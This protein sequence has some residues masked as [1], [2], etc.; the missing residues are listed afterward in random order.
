MSGPH[1]RNWAELLVGIGLVLVFAVVLAEAARYPRDARLFPVFI[2]VAGLGMALILV[3]RGLRHPGGRAAR[4]D[5]D[6]EGAGGTGGT[7]PPTPLWVAILAAPAFGV[8]MWL[9]GFWVPTGLVV[10]LGPW[11]MGYRDLRRRVALTVG[12]LGV[13][14]FMFPYLL[15]VPLPTGLVFDELFYVDDE[16]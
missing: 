11:V 2:G 7:A 10:L 16:D 3:A 12:T 13:L 1:R 5:D 6:G 8:T 9:L 15:N 4:P 14:A